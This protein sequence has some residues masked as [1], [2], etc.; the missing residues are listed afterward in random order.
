MS[1]LAWGLLLISQLALVAGQIL[2]KGAMSRREL[3][4]GKSAGWIG[5]LA[6][7]IATMTIWFLLWLGVMH[8]VELSKLMPLEGLSPLLIVI[9]AMIFL[10]ERLNWHGWA[11]V[12]LTCV[13]V[14][15]VSAS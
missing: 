6:L 7:G 10:R 11:G 15:L 3:G 9:G 8:Q 13:G 5:Q 14:L 12:V 1:L 2:L 4:A